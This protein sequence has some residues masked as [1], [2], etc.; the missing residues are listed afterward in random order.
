MIEK[1]SVTNFKSHAQTEIELGRVTAIVGPNGCGK[2]SLLLAVQ[3]LNQTAKQFVAGSW[4]TEELHKQM[5]QGNQALSLLAG[6]ENPQ[7]I[8]EAALNGGSHCSFEFENKKWTPEQSRPIRKFSFG[9]PSPLPIDQA[10]V[11]AFGGV[12][13]FK[14]ISQSVALP[15]HTLDIPPQINQDGS[16]LASVIAYLMTYLPEKHKLIEENLKAIVPLVKRVRVHPA[17]ITV[18]EKRT[19]SANGNS[20]AYDEDRQVVGHELFF[21]TTSGDGLPASTMSDGTLI[22]L[23]ILSVLHTSDANLIMFD[24]IEQGLHPLAQR[25]LIKTLKVFAEKHN[26]PILLTS[27]S[28]YIIDELDAKDVWVMTLDDEGI[29]RCKRLSD[30]HDAERLLQVLTTGELADAVGE[31]WVIDPQVAAGVAND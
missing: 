23:A 18:K 7:W 19:I 13:Y 31:D 29:S 14:A 28:G 15:S 5:R 21:D 11:Q 2:S 30:H 6:G 4:N 22:T 1:V 10:A 24:D 8:V 16:G 9:G 12:A 25:Q 26:K 20:I 27:H 17:K 3:I